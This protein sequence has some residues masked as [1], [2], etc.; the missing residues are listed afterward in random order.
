MVDDQIDVRNSQ[1][2]EEVAVGAAPAAS[3]MARDELS[4]LRTQLTAFEMVIKRLQLELKHRDEHQ[5]R[6]DAQLREL[7]EELVK[8]RGRKSKG[9]HEGP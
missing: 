8:L 2:V 9:P 5:A 3:R 6:T 4:M 1:G 7:T